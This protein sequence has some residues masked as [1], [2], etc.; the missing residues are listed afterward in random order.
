MKRQLLS[1]LSLAALSMP[2]FAGVED[3]VYDP[4]DGVE[5][6]NLYNISRNLKLEEFQAAA[7]A[8]F[9][10][11]TRSMAVKD[12][13]LYIAH[14]RTKIVGEESNDYANLLIYDQITGAFENQVQLT[15]GGEPITGLL[16]ANQIGID[17]FGNM[18][19][20]GLCGSTE[21]TPWKLYHVK[22]IATG[23]TELIAELTVPADEAQAFGRHDYYDLV[24]DVTGKQAGTVVMSP[25]AN[26]TSTFVIG[27]E[28]QQGSDQWG[29][30]MTGG[31]YYAQD[32]ADTYPAGLTT[33]NG[34]P[35]IRIIRDDS[36]SGNLYYVDAFVGYPT[37]YDVEGALID[38]FAGQ[39]DVI[40]GA[41]ANA[42]G[43]NEFSL[44]D[45]DYVAFAKTDYDKGEG[46]QIRVA[47]LGEGKAFTGSKI[48]W[49]LPAKGLGTITDSGSRMFGIC[50]T[51]VTD[52]A[53]KYGCYLSIYKCNNGLA[54]YLISEPG[55]K[56]G[57]DEV[58]A[59]E[60]VNAPV[61]MYNLNGVR[62][63]GDVA[64]GLYIRRQG[65]TVT[66]VVI[67]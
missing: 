26:G 37:I 7:F 56:A 10:N 14:S 67:R 27:F 15:V 46:S 48:A 25:V 17:D 43:M 22:D 50:P 18:W 63:N 19:L 8:E 35:Q 1:I 13:K 39:L 51:V 47:R 40:D 6:K 65:S 38:S 64:P 57:V 12:G 11:K 52:E 66:K 16:C 55:F 61:E 60:D 2:A 58:V 62:V 24:G 42:N 54:T 20:M 49:D 33:W 4:A 29:P 5:C 31:E 36:Y 53:G 32:M 34:A 28:R 44:G 9:N 41:N 3:Y 23:E 30:H 21:K 59:D 45:K